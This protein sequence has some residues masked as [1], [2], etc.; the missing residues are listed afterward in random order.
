M[1]FSQDDTASGES[2]FPV[3]S[4]YPPKSILP[5]VL[6]T[7]GFYILVAQSLKCSCKSVKCMFLIKIVSMYFKDL[8]LFYGQDFPS[9]FF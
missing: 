8:A 7:F 1:I 3:I 9:H 4:H 2:G 6:V 5:P